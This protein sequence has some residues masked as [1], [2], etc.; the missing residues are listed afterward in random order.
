MPLVAL[1][2][3]GPSIPRL[4][5]FVSYA[6][7]DDGIAAGDHGWVT[8]FVLNLDKQ[9]NMTLGR[10]GASIFMDHQ[11]AAGNNVTPALHRAATTAKTLLI[12]MS[13]GYQQSPWCQQHELVAFLERNAA[14]AQNVFVVEMLAADRSTWHQR[15][16][17]LKTVQLWTKDPVAVG[18][19]LLGYPKPAE[20]ESNP[21]WLKI[22]DLAFALAQVLEQQQP[23]L[24][25]S[26]SP[27]DLPPPEPP[28]PAVSRVWVAQ[29]VFEL[30]EQW[31]L[32]RAALSREQIEVLPQAAQVYPLHSA[33]AFKEAADKDMARCGLMVH[34]LGATPG[35]RFGESNARM[36]GL[37]SQLLEMRATLD[38]ATRILTWRAPGIDVQAVADPV[39]KAQ[40]LAASSETFEQFRRSVLAA[41]GRP[42]EPILPVPGDDVS[43]GICVA[44]GIHDA[45]TCKELLDVIQTMGHRA[46]QPPLQPAP[47]QGSGEYQSSVD[48]VIQAC[49]AMIL[50]YG[51]E[52]AAWVQ[53]QYLRAQRLLAKRRRRLWGAVLDAP[54]PKQQPPQIADR[55]LMALDCRNGVSPSEVQRFLSALLEPD[56]A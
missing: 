11:L 5:V 27:P 50:V 3:V 15:L 39:H 16:Q 26:A 38:P 2:D 48:S 35:P 1:S 24:P 22:N 53:A 10:H 56:H 13:K 14:S 6:H 37:Q 19:R 33:L 17:D 43:L 29:P 31:D 12:F 40:L 8:R 20:D 9:L 42:L 46:V 49:D 54:P 30:T 7:V 36:A 45:D 23:L 44:A 55:R 47:N 28:A 25:K 18:P 52:S 51:S 32:L 21:Y 41:C 34:L 4:D